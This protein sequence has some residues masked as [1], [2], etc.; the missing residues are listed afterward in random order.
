MNLQKH[1]YEVDIHWKEGRLGTMSSPVLD[2]KVEVATPPQFN[3]GVE[4]VW[5]PEHLLVASLSSCFMTTFTAIAE[6]SKLNLND[7]QVN[8]AG[9]L[10]KLDGKFMMTEIALK[11][12]LFIEEEKQ[13]DKAYRILE[14]AEKGCLISNSLKT[15]IIF[16]PNVAVG[17]LD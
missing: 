10:D 1:A 7:L 9:R 6:N 17:V 3:G 15:K 12:E 4:G 11:P 5:S 2:Q 14:K 8:A 16:E 13:T